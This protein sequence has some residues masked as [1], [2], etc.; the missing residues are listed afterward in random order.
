[1]KVGI[2]SPPDISLSFL[3]LSELKMKI[4]FDFFEIASTVYDYDGKLAKKD[5]KLVVK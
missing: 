4:P 2:V 3:K 5:G 1:M